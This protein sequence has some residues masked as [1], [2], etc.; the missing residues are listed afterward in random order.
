MGNQETRAEAW[1]SLGTA[2]AVGSA[3][4]PKAV[5]HPRTVIVPRRPGF[6]REYQPRSR[7]PRDELD[8]LIDKLFG[9]S[10]DEKPGRFDA[11]LAVVGLILAAWAIILGGPSVALWIGIAA[12]VLGLALPARALLRRLDS[13]PSGGFRRR[14]VDGGLPLDASQPA[15]LALIGAYA[16][17]MQM[18]RMQGT[19][20]PKQALLAGHAAVVE[21]AR[22]LDGQ[23]PDTPAK[24][25]FVSMRTGA[26]EALTHQ[27]LRSRDHWLAQAA[28]QT[29]ARAAL[30]HS[31]PRQIPIDHRWT[32][33]RAQARSPNSRRPTTNSGRRS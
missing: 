27:M 12:T 10:T 2:P 32:P 25:R 26:L 22:R 6:L 4:A 19:G 24:V 16:R 11:G 3:D 5:V 23:A 8:D 1:S 31:T 14:I 15:T 33:P 29:Q 30:T 18:S 7:R 13:S 17:L 28:I 9:P 21:V 20:N